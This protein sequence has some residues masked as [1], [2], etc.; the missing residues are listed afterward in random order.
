MVTRF[1]VA[2]ATCG[3][4]K[5]TIETAVSKLAGVNEVALDLDSKLLRVDHD[6]ALRVEDVEATINAA[7]YTPQKV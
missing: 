4:C 5:G 7:G 6:E 1:Q 3:H 2:D